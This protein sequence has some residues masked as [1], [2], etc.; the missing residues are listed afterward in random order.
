AATLLPITTYVLVTEP[1]RTLSDVLKYRGAVSDTER[2]DN[3]YRILEDDRL[4]WS[5][6]MTVWEAQPKLF[7]RGLINDIKRNF[8]ALGDVQVAQMW[9]GTLGS[10]V[11]RM[12][13]IGETER[14]VWVASGFGGH[15]LNTTAMAGELIARGLVDGDDTWRLFAPYELV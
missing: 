15:G 11:H 7:A 10:S 12:P 3:H 4:Q 2:A 13:Q 14:G 1:I 9:H 5:G 6:R 8:P